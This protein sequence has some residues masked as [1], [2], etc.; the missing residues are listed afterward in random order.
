MDKNVIMLVLSEYIQLLL[1]EYFS[2]GLLVFCF[3]SYWSVFFTSIV[4]VDIEKLIPTLLTG[5]ICFNIKVLC[6]CLSI[7]DNFPFGLSFYLFIISFRRISPEL[8]SATN[9]PLFAEEDWP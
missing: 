8:T 2:V 1:T 7:C 3:S 6:L 5:K 9:P 4:D